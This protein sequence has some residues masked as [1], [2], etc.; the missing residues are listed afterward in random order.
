ML[1]VVIAQRLVGNVS[2]LLPA[3]AVVTN[4]ARHQLDRILL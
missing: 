4:F 2:V 3:P 1:S